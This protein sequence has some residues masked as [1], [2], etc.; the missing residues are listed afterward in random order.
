M[1][2]GSGGH[3]ARGETDPNCAHASC[4]IPRFPAQ[5]MAR[6]QIPVP[7]TGR[8]RLARALIDRLSLASLPSGGRQS[9]AMC[10]LPGQACLPLSQRALNCT[11]THICRRE[12]AA[13]KPCLPRDGVPSSTCMAWRALPFLGSCCSAQSQSESHATGSASRRNVRSPV[14]QTSREIR[15]AVMQHFPASRLVAI[16][17]GLGD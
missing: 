14:R 11:H 9:N 4:F 13:I 8:G 2:Q 12:C 5:Q 6:H 17:A 3:G 7:S 10:S 16:A 1:G 15:L